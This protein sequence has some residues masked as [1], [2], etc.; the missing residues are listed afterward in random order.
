MAFSSS[1]LIASAIARPEGPVSIE[2]D[3]F[4]R[5]VESITLKRLIK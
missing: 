4:E 5:D 1:G 2:A 3:A